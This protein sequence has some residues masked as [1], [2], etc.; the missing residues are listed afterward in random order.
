MLT[1]VVGAGGATGRLLVHEL[2]ERGE[3]VRILVRSPE[4]LPAQVTGHANLSVIQASVLVISDTEM[5]GH[6]RGCDALVSCLGHPL[7]M[8]GV[9]GPPYRLVTDATRRL[10]RAVRANNPTAPVKFVLMN[11][12][13]NSNRDLDEKVSFGQRCVMGLLRLA[14]PPHA[15]NENAADYLRT[16][17]G[18]SDAVIEWSA[19]RPDSLRNDSEVTDYTVHPSPTRSAIFDAGLCSRINVS[20]FMAELITSE[21]T[22]KN[23]RGKMPVIYNKTIETASARAS[24]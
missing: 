22:W 18:Q 10:C 15:D 17:I 9:L 13:G 14:L 2:L 8:K 12:A 16:E 4:N 7:N 3:R 19:V 24:H 23:W 20:H 5:S 1:L 11:T 21:Q 6:V